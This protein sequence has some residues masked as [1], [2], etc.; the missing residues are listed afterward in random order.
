[1]DC[2]ALDFLLLCL[3]VVE[4]LDGCFVYNMIDLLI[5]HILGFRFG[6]GS[7]SG[8]DRVGIGSGSGRVRVGVGS[9]G[10]VAGDGS[11]T[12]HNSRLA[13]KLL[14]AWTLTNICQVPASPNNCFV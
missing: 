8:R 4:Q 7:G 11:Q 14:T 2:C 10:L 13:H 6:L 5:F 12:R 3:H 9:G 1:M